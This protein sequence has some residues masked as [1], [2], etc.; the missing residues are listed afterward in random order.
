MLRAVFVGYENR[1]NRVVNHW[2]STHTDLVG[3][4][5]IPSSTTW[6]TSRSGRQ[7]FLRRRI[8]KRGIVKALVEAAVHLFYH[9]T[10]RRSYNHRAANAL[11]DEYW[12]NVGFHSW[13]PFIT[14][15]KINDPRVRYYLD[16]LKPDVI[17]SHCIHQFF[18]RKLRESAKHG[19]LLWHVGITPEYKGLYAPFWTMHNADFKNFGYSLFRLNDEIDAGDVFVQGT[20]S[21]V[22]IRRDNHHLIEHKAILASL[23]AVGEFIKNLENGTAK[24]IQRTDAI[25]GYYTYPG[26]TD[27]I[28]QRVRVHRALRNGLPASPSSAPLSDAGTPQIVTTEQ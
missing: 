5:W 16:Q 3:S 24:P 26:M 27:Y 2:L 7:S 20:I 13:G 10:A 9:S 4:V 1:L 14:V 11:I 22:D 21:N 25:P 6:Q 23:P 19:V 17:F 15:S 18:G 8:E 12:R 28:R